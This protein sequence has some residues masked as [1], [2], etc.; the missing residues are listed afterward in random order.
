VPGTVDRFRLVT[1]NR[2]AIG[3]DIW[4][5][6][7][8]LTYRQS[9]DDGAPSLV[10]EVSDPGGL[11]A[12]SSQIIEPYVRAVGSPKA[13]KLRPVDVRYDG[14]W[15]RL[16][17]ANVINDTL[18]L[19]FSHRF[20]VYMQGEKGVMTAKR[21]AMTR[22]QFIRQQVVNTAKKKTASALLPFWSPYLLKKMPV[23]K[24]DATDLASDA[25]VDRS[26]VDSA[27]ASSQLKGIT[28]VGKTATADQRTNIATIASVG[29]GLKASER[30]MLAAYCAAIGESN[31]SAVPN[32]AGSGYWGVFQGA[33]TTFAID[34]T[35]G[36]AECFFQGGKGF[37]AGGAIALAKANP[38]YTPGQIAYMVEGDLS[39]FSG[40][41]EA[42]Q[43][44]DKHQTEAK[45]MLA[46]SQGISPT[47]IDASETGTSYGSGKTFTREKDDDAWSSTGDLASEVQKRRFVLV[48]GSGDDLFVYSS[49]EDLIDLLPSQATI[50]LDAG[51][52]GDYEYDVDH[53]AAASV[54]TCELNLSEFGSLSA[55]LP[56]NVPNAG[57]GTGKWI[58][59][60]VEEEQGQWASVTLHAPMATLLEPAGTDSTDL[61]RLDAS[62]FPVDSTGFGSAAAGEG[63][64]GVLAKAK[65]ISARNLPYGPGGHGQ[66]WSEAD[67]ASSLDCSSSTS[68]ALNGGGLMPTPLVGPQVSDYFLGWGQAGE[69]SHMTVWV[70][71]GTGA[72]GHVFTEF[73]IP[74]EKV[75]WFDTSQQAGGPSG[76]HVRYGERSTAG[77]TPRH[78]GS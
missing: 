38:S 33:K 70:K 74:G 71:P 4:A 56:V 16:V 21:S 2:A 31:V 37:Q 61:Q 58:V 22:A 77:F 63:V 73:K 29:A 35:K 75:R 57:A 69:G 32:G 55:G 46:S 12:N 19:T 67:R 15:Y 20:V 1:A 9:M 44:Y 60:E 66:T 54:L 28:V 8:Q 43:F 5:A 6:V 50:N 62:D 30:V 26:V 41:A 59:W 42:A 47:A 34:D 11:L 51:Y 53:G 14:V 18:Q 10:L 13:W 76:P 3:T 7:D 78:W 27:D 40:P 36:M 52:V 23:A 48:R 72:N 49:D 65:E 17:S 39:N 45:A 25:E 24:A 64:A 68:V